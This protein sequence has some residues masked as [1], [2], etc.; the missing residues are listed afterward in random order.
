MQENI[1]RAVKALLGRQQ[2]DG[3][4]AGRLSVNLAPSA[5]VLILHRYY[6]LG[7]HDIEGNFIPPILDG[8]N[9]DG[10]W[11]AYPSGPSD[12]DTSAEIALGLSVCINPPRAELDRAQRFIEEHGGI[13]KTFFTIKSLYALLDKWRWDKVWRIPMWLF[14]LP[15][16]IGLASL[17]AWARLLSLC[18]L[19]MGDSGKKAPFSRDLRSRVIETLRLHQ[20]RN[21]SWGGMF[22]PTFLALMALRKQG[23]KHTDPMVQWGFRFIHSLQSVRENGIVQERYLAKIWDTAL[24]IRALRTCGLPDDHQAILRGIDYLSLQQIWHPHALKWASINPTGGWAFEEDNTL[25][26]DADDTSAAVIALARLKGEREAEIERQMF[27]GVGWLLRQQ[28]PHGGFG[29]FDKEIRGGI[30][31]WG[32]R[33]WGLMCSADRRWMWYYRTRDMATPDITGHAVEALFAGGLTSAHKA[34]GSAV[35]YLISSQTRSGAWRGR[36]GVGAIYGTS[37]ALRGLRSAGVAKSHPCILKALQWLR[38]IQ[39]PDG[40]WGEPPESLWKQELWGIGP[41]N[42]TQTAWA[43]LG[44]VASG[45]V[46]SQGVKRG[47]EYLLST[48]REDGFWDEPFPTG[49]LMPPD[50]FLSYEFYPLIFPLMALIDVRKEKGA[51]AV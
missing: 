19:L 33:I 3:S 35:D 17:P 26:P 36:W 43:I 25:F 37:M 50:Y 22:T 5:D 4:W 6:E 9:K 7:T 42:P 49:V 16:G 18:L 14:W 21:G 28:N 23:F 1:E 27:R 31:E 32:A 39:Q 11:S 45:E 47:V 34:I 44:L 10:G 51:T 13:G 46:E 24:A 15:R 48:Q 40:G 2:D 41:S 30:W 38:S 20:D 12:L 29:S 8:Q